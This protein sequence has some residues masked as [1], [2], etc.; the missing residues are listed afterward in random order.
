MNHFIMERVADGAVCKEKILSYLDM[1][2][3]NVYLSAM[4]QSL[5]YFQDPTASAVC[6]KAAWEGAGRIVRDDATPVILYLP[7]IAVGAET[8]DGRVENVGGGD[9]DGAAGKSGYRAE[10]RPVNV[11]DIRATEGDGVAEPERP[12]IIERVLAYSGATSEVIE[13]EALLDPFAHGFYDRRLNVIFLERGLDLAGQEAAMAAVLIGMVFEELEIAD[14]LL[15]MAVRYAVLGRY[16][17]DAQVS[18]ALFVKLDSY[19]K[20]QRQAFL[21]GL[22]Q[23]VLEVVQRIEGRGLMFEETAFVNCLFTDDDKGGIV[24]RCMR[25]AEN[26]EDEMLSD[27][28][29]RFGEKVLYADDAEVRRLFRMRMERKVVTYPVVRWGSDWGR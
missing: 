27:G 6:G 26:A 12:M 8:G 9:S 20:E 10:Y 15:E 28:L 19:D 22:S 18:K 1:V 17:L 14:P 29:R 21:I 16:G 2:K 5:L 23:V 7:E 3:K 11:F 24:Y 4:N 13:R 25:A